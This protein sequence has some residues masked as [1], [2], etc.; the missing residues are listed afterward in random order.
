M[1]K[2]GLL[3]MERKPLNPDQSHWLSLSCSVLWVAIK[4]DFCVWTGSSDW[5]KGEN[6][7]LL[8]LRVGS[9]LPQCQNRAEGLHARWAAPL[10]STAASPLHQCLYSFIPRLSQSER[11]ICL[12]PFSSRRV[13]PD[14]CGGGELLIPGGGAQGCSLPDPDLLCQRKGQADPA[15]GLQ[16]EGRPPATREEPELGGE[17]AEDPPSLSIH[18]GLPHHQSG[19]C[20]GGE[21]RKSNDQPTTCFSWLYLQANVVE[22]WEE[23]T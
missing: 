16:P 19:V 2:I 4:S 11:L 14:L 13:H 1:Y 8:V 23:R 22:M 9:D 17:A 15:A 10:C 3:Q 18:P 21:S 7:V 12:P 6:S 5:Y 20:P